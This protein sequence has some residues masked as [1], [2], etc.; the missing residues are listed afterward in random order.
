MIRGFSGIFRQRDEHPLRN[1]LGEVG[2]IHH[3]DRSGMHEIDV[4]PDQLGERRFGAAFGVGAQQLQIGFC[5][6]LPISSRRM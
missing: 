4:P 5:V 2:V 3:P 6:H 1:V